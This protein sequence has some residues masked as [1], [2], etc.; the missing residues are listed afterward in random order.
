MII[1]LS[2]PQNLTLSQFVPLVP[3]IIYIFYDVLALKRF[4]CSL[5]LSLSKCVSTNTCEDSKRQR[6]RKFGP[7]SQ[8]DSVWRVALFRVFVLFFFSGAKK[9][10][11]QF[12]RTKRH[13]TLCSRLWNVRKN[14]D[15]FT[16][17]IKKRE[18]LCFS[19]SL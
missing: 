14:H 18:L 10:S 4:F 9:K 1:S 2:S 13:L 19:L 12:V 8:N 6:E 3:P 11:S 16:K 7:S 15:D 17:T 5:S